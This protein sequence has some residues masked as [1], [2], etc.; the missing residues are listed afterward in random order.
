MIDDGTGLLTIGQLSRGTGLPVRTI[1][2]RLRFGVPD[3]PD[4]PT[5]EPLSTHREAFAWVVA[6]LRAQLGS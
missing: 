1:R 6:A 4:D 5:T 3:L 2:T